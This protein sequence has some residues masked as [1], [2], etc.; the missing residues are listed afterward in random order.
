MV[1]N[2]NSLDGAATICQMS[3]LLMTSAPSQTVHCRC[4]GIFG[5]GIG[6]RLLQAFVTFLTPCGRGTFNM[7]HHLSF[8]GL[9]F[10]ELPQHLLDFHFKFSSRMSHVAEDEGKKC[11]KAEE[12]MSTRMEIII[13][14]YF[15]ASLCRSSSICNRD[16]KR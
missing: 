3:I 14:R 15:V 5:M 16:L 11:V 7:F 9:P 12:K 1:L 4:K 13:N 10:G 2:S 8:D 6:C